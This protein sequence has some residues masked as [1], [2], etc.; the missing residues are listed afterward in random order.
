MKRIVFA[1]LAVLAPGLAAGADLKAPPFKAL[2]PVPVVPC[3]VTSCTSF[4]GGLDITG[5]GSN[6][7]V[8]GNGLN[9]SLN[10]NGTEIGLHAGFR[11]YD[12]K[13]YLGAEAGCGYDVAMQMG[14]IGQSPTDRLR[15]MELLKGGGSL[16][17]LFGGATTFPIPPALQNSFMSFYGILGASERFNATGIAGG[18]GAEFVISPKVTMTLDYININYTGGGATASSIATVPNENLFRLGVNYNF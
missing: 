15:C 9:G 4:Y 1:C 16:A 7:N 6:V 17:A 11:T 10:A 14:V 12:G 18:V 5:A 8:L 13:I 2:A 3:T